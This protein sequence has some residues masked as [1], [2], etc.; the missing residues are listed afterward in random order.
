MIQH[1]INELCKV[2]SKEQPLSRSCALAIL[3][4]RSEEIPEIL[5]LT[6]ALRLRNFGNKAHLCS[7]L[8]A[9]SGA[10]EEDCTFCAQ[11]AHHKTDVET[12][13]LC[14]T[15]KMVEQFTK[16]A[17][18]PIG[19]FGV[20][21]SGDSM[22][23]KEVDTLCQAIATG[24]INGT[25]WCAS[26]GNLSL[27]Q[28]QKLK[29]A[30]LK[31]FHHN[32]ETAES[33][34]PTICTTHT[35]Q[36]RLDMIRNVKKAGLELCCGG[37]LGLGESFEQ[38]IELAFTLREEGVNAIPLNFHIPVSGTKLQNNTPLSPMEIIKAIALFR[39]ANPTAEIKVCAGRTHLRDLQSMIFYAGATGMMIGPLLTVAGR[40]V[41]ADVQM[42]KDLEIS[43]EQP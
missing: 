10:C 33:F 25:A 14:S 43:F 13:A 41:D 23:D 15:Q 7:I 26:L 16:H 38:R 32:L 28:L 3:K 12:Y 1:E 17:A 20:V 11:S 24:E 42:L 35:Y 18:Y 36:S 40:D 29:Q 6:N 31:R 2:V 21:T 27:E 39:M 9:K 34:F 19:H 30:G 37:L 8:N 22:D 5:T 4:A